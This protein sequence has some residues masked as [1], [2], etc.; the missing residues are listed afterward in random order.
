MIS[1][2][3]L[4]IT[5]VI[6]VVILVGGVGSYLLTKEPKEVERDL[7]V[8][9]ENE[10]PDTKTEVEEDFA[11]VE[12]P[13]EDIPGVPVDEEE[14]PTPEEVE[15]IK[16]IETVQEVKDVVKPPEEI[17]ADNAVIEK[18]EEE[19]AVHPDVQP[20][21]LQPVE[22][23][24][25]KEEPVKD[26][27]GFIY[28]KE[29]AVKMFVDKI[30]SY[31][32]TSSNSIASALAYAKKKAERKGREFDQE[33]FDADLNQMLTDPYSSPRLASML[34]RFREDGYMSGLIVYCSEWLSLGGDDGE[35]AERETR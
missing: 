4:I 28:T 10:F 18:A 9:Y 5:S 31:P 22:I 15:E 17:V 16:E 26:A 30:K 25:V 7:P 35:W 13:E 12:L 34:D 29:Q 2:K 8:V 27:D 23:E 33:A 11:D 24:P 20:V 14:L 3:R 19:A 6:A 32:D 1:N 21:P